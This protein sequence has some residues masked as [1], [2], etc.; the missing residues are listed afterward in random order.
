MMWCG[1]VPSRL[2]GVLFMKIIKMFP[3]SGGA[4]SRIQASAGCCCSC[5]CCCLSGS[6]SQEIA[7]KNLV[8]GAGVG[9]VLGTGFW[10]YFEFIYPAQLRKAGD[11][12]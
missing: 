10:A 5:S 3:S 6:T 11:N 4:P 7:L 1:L 9:T 8:L 2:F 12:L